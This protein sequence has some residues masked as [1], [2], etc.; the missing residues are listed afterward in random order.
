MEQPNSA[1][2]GSE[3]KISPKALP[4]ARPPG[5]AAADVFRSHRERIGLENKIYVHATVDNKTI[6]LPWLP[7]AQGSDASRV[8]DAGLDKQLLSCS[9]S[10]AALLRSAINRIDILHFYEDSGDSWPSYLQ[11]YSHKG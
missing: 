6:F 9:I 1:A 10:W 4:S 8:A 5:V 2:F 7:I 3:R 11:K